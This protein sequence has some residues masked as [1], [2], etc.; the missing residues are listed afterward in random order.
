TRSCPSRPACA[1]HSLCIRGPS[2]SRR[3]PYTTLFRSHHQAE[4]AEQ[5]TRSLEQMARSI[6]EV[7]G[8]AGEV[9]EAAARG[10]ERAR[11]G[12]DAVRSEEHTSEL[13]S[14]EN[15]VCRLLLEKKNPGSACCARS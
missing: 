15:L 1:V 8:S 3:W 13:Q 7:S 10:A 9:A 2:R 12:D 6:E 11:A 14:R 4:K 5:T